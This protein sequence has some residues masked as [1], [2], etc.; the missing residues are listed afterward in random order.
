MD[1]VLLQKLPVS[2]LVVITM[3]RRPC[4]WSLCSPH[5]MIISLR[6]ILIGEP[7]GGFFCWDTVTKLQTGLPRS[8]GSNH[9]RGSAVY[10][11][12]VC[13]GC[14][15]ALSVIQ[16]VPRA[17]SSVVMRSEFEAGQSIR[18]SAEVNLLAPEL[19]LFLILAHPVHK[20]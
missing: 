13:T 1:G 3:F 2:Q 16:W 10:L 8:M 17:S 19:C 7:G 18:L 9:G 20:M 15:A 11:H 6:C 12:T 14:G 4:Q 5:R